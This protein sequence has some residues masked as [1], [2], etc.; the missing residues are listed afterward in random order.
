MP[1]CSAL[2]SSCTSTVF[3]VLGVANAWFGALLWLLGERMVMTLLG[4]AV[5]SSRHVCVLRIEKTLFCW[6]E[7]RIT[8]CVSCHSV[9]LTG[10]CCL[11]DVLSDSLGDSVVWCVQC[12]FPSVLYV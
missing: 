11:S 2:T 6:C 7:Y 3:K 4:H 12:V 8:A 5:W 9:M 10:G 1:A